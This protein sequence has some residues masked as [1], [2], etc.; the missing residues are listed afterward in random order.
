[1]KM[2]SSELLI[3]LE[4]LSKKEM[5]NFYTY[6]NK[7]YRKGHIALRLFQYLRKYHPDFETKKVSYEKAFTY[8]FPSRSFNK[9]TVSNAISDIKVKLDQ[10]FVMQHIQDNEYERK[11]ILLQVYKRYQVDKLIKN[12]FAEMDRVLNRVQQKDHTYWLRKALLE[13]EYYSSVNTER[14]KKRSSILSADKNLD[15]FYAAL[16]LKIG[17]K[18]F[19][20]YRLMDESEPKV[21]FLSEIESLNLHQHSFYHLFYHLATRMF[22]ERDDGIYHQ[23]KEDFF[24][25]HREVSVEDQC[26]LLTYLL[27]HNAKE[28]RKGREDLGEETF[29]LLKFGLEQELF[30][31]QGYLYPNHFLNAI[32]IAISIEKFSWTE[33]VIEEWGGKLEPTNRKYYNSLGKAILCLHTQKFEECLDYLIEVDKKEPQ[34]ELRGRWLYIATHYELGNRTTEHILYKYDAFKN[35]VRNNKLI[36]QELKQAVTSSLNI[37][38]VFLTEKPDKR[39]ILNLIET[40]KGFFYKKWLKQKAEEL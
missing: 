24:N 37:L 8:L 27:N 6:L 34:N 23:L 10:Y 12:N 28:I 7:Q 13:L 1:M 16:K 14:L 18:I 15:Y 17:S 4:K 29:E 39:R 38:K 20:G 3:L 25:H 33:K 11:A 9:I 31:F 22:D 5:K 35:Y 36:S 30:N 2:Y 32:E 26:T 19:N 40:S 21:S